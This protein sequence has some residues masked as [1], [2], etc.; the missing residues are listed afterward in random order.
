MHPS[1]GKDFR[2]SKVHK[3]APEDNSPEKTRIAL[4]AV[5]VRPLGRS[6]R[7]FEMP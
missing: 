3:T 1:L 7:G 5:R 6:F 2:L 4:M